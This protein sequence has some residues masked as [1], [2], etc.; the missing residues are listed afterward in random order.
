LARN[1]SFGF[2]SVG[3]VCRQKPNVLFV[4]LAYSSLQ[5]TVAATQSVQ[6]H[7]H[8]KQPIIFILFLKIHK[9]TPTLPGTFCVADVARCASSTPIAHCFFFL[10]YLSKIP[11][12]CVLQFVC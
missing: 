8:S 2:L 3:S 4:R 12:K 10:F 7:T 1:S 9:K 5:R 11:Q 6:N